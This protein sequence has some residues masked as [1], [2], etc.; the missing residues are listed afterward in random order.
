MPLTPRP[1]AE[2]PLAHPGKILGEAIDAMGVGKAEVAR[3]LGVTRK[4]LYDIL[5]GK[6]AVSAPMALRLEA[7]VGSSAEFWLGLQSQHDLWRAR[8]AQPIARAGTKQATGRR[9]T[10][11]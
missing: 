7:V 8:Q 11:A 6:S 3:R 5:G 2:F 9:R 4:M 10:A 1:H